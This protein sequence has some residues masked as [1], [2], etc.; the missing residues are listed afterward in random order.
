MDSVWGKF[1]RA[2][3]LTSTSEC[4]S[5]MEVL[6]H[7]NKVLEFKLFIHSNF[8]EPLVCTSVGSKENR[9]VYRYGKTYR[10]FNLENPT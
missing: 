5:V 8:L 9:T 2:F 6:M 10:A 3:I 1:V 4:L 7:S